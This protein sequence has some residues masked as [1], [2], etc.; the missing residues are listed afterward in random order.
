M[1]YGP[2]RVVFAVDGIVGA[3]IF[4]PSQHVVTLE[5]ATYAWLEEKLI[6]EGAPTR[7]CGCCVTWEEC[8]LLVL[9]VTPWPPVS[10]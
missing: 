10:P 4:T 7:E 3:E 5:I 8:D 6:A 2:H 9:S 1:Y